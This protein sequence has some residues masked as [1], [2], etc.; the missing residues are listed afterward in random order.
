MYCAALVSTCMVCVF[1]WCMCCMKV[2]CSGYAVSVLCCMSEGV[3]VEF[4]DTCSHCS[5]QFL[6]KISLHFV[7]S[8]MTAK[9]QGRLHFINENLRK[10]VFLSNWVIQ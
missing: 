3:W 1:V 7:N 2:C 6:V 10:Q 9:A 8:C 4:V 5:L